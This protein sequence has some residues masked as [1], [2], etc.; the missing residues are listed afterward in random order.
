M[1]SFNYY[2]QLINKKPSIFFHFNNYLI[3]FLQSSS[4]FQNKK[5]IYFSKRV[6]RGSPIRVKKTE[7]EVGTSFGCTRDHAFIFD[8]VRTHYTLHI[9]SLSR[10]KK[11]YQSL[12]HF[13]SKHYFRPHSSRG[14]SKEWVGI[15][16]FIWI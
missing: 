10:H 5:W 4:I 15:H 6:G 9:L 2:W 7:A 12:F 3:G 1:V 16:N 13:Q 11:S 14:N 8:F